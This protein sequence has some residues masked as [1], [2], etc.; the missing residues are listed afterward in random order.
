MPN[1]K[2][3]QPTKHHYFQLLV[4]LFLL[5]YCTPELLSQTSAHCSFNQLCTCKY[6][7]NANGAGGSARPGNGGGAGVGLRNNYGGSN[8]QQGTTESSYQGQFGTITTRLVGKFIQ[9]IYPDVGVSYLFLQL[10]QI[11]VIMF[12]PAAL[13]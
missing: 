4:V 13:T 7:P 1:N 6:A 11:V 12:L 2:I 3:C 5:C 10:N 9:K 8:N